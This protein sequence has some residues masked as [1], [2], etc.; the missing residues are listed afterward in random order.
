MS[1]LHRVVSRAQRRLWFIRW[2]HDLGWSAAGAAGVF[3]A[4]VLINRLFSFGWP[5]AVIAIGLAGVALVGS[6]VW[7]VLTR[8]DAITAATRLDENAGLKERL[9]TG[10]FIETGRDP[11]ERAVQRDAERI[12]AGLTVSQ[13]I[14]FVWPESLGYGLASVVAAVL[15]TW[16]M[17]NY[18]LLG[19]EKQRDE[20]Q[21]EQKKLAQ[22]RENILQ[23]IERVKKVARRNT[24]LKDG[25][26]ME[27]LDA[28]ATMQTV[29]PETLRREAIK[30]LGKLGD[31]LKA[32]RDAAKFDAVTQMK[33]MLR[34]LRNPRAAP[35]PV[36]KLRNALA[37]GDF[38]AAS[39]A[40][41]QVQ[42]QLAQAQASGD[43]MRIDQLQK[44]MNALAVKLD[45]V[46]KARK[47][48][49]NQL[50]QAGLKKEQIEKLLA[51]LP[52]MN[53]GQLA[54][55]LQQANPNLSEQQLQKLVRQMM[56][57]QG[58]AQAAQQ[59]AQN[60]QNM[61]GQMGQ[62]GQMQ[63][64]QGGEGMMAAAAQLSELEQLEQELDELQVTLNEI[65]MGMNQL[66]GGQGQG[67]GPGQGQGFGQNMARQGRG[68]GGGFRPEDEAAY[69][70]R[71]RKAKIKTGRGQI[72]GQTFIDGK[73]FAGDATSE[74]IEAVQAAQ[75]DTADAL[76]DDRIPRK[77]HPAIRN[78][79]RQIDAVG[80][81]APAS[82][83]TGP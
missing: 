60:L 37:K 59:L 74:F 57:N 16:L 8:E 2:C 28:L 82:S 76:A 83:G 19:R 72:I 67:P 81:A 30:K 17:P 65:Q 31:D 27:E 15:L 25:A 50:K 22:V 51:N 43:Q 68:A 39:E 12:S 52:K 11:F 3:V 71:R 23:Q 44:Q 77:Y 42:A 55:A 54:K 66:G 41:K 61:A 47:Q 29:A 14:R 6:V 69:R 26:A 49:A 5:L 62:P 40:L 35:S 18:D 1:G 34:E 7:C 78:Y 38:K 70:L 63:G 4:I 20:Q 64:G 73:Q 32:R 80:Q 36:N 21:V 9:S 75:D 24:D 46:A 53:A 13:H 56:Q 58:A 10:L 48:T 33:N 79:Y 45:K